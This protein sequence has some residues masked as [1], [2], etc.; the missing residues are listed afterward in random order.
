M[1]PQVQLTADRGLCLQQ[2]AEMH[3]KT[4]K[5]RIIHFSRWL[6]AILIVA[7]ATVLF[8]PSIINWQI[9]RILK[10]LMPEGD[11]AELRLSHVGIYRSEF[12]LIVHDDK[13]P[14]NFSVRLDSGLLEYHPLRLL[15]RQIDSI[16]ISG[17]TV[18]L[19]ATNGVLNV[20]AADLFAKEGESEPFT[21]ES[22][23]SLPVKVSRVQIDG[24]IVAKTA[25]ELIVV[26]L[27]VTAK[28]NEGR[29][30]D[31]ISG[32]A[33][34]MLASNRLSLDMEC[35]IQKQTASATVDGVFSSFSLPYSLRRLIPDFLYGINANTEAAANVRFNGAKLAEFEVHTQLDA[36]AYTASGPI[37]LRPEIKASGDA[38]RFSVSVTGIRSDAS[39]FPV[40]FNATNILCDVSAGTVDGTAYIGISSNT[41]LAIAFGYAT[42]SFHAATKPGDTANSGSLRVGDVAFDY[43]APSTALKATFE[44]GA[45]RADLSVGIPYVSYTAADTAAT[46]FI[47]KADAAGGLGTITASAEASADLVFRDMEVA[48]ISA[49]GRLPKAGPFV[50]EGNIAAIGATLKF[51]GDI[52]PSDRGGIRATNYIAMAE[53]PL[54]LTTIQKLIP[55]LDGVEIKTKAKVSGGYF[56]EGGK[57]GGAV[58]LV[59]SEGAVDWPE[60]RFSAS[61]IRLSFSL[62][63]LPELTSDSQ[64]LRFKNLKYRRAEVESG[65]LVF[66]MHSP[67]VWF[68]DNL[69]LD[70]C[71]GKVRGESTRLSPEN[72]RTRITLH[73]DRINVSKLLHQIGIGMDSGG[74]GEISGTIPV[75]ISREDGVVFRDAFLYSTPGEK[76]HIELAPSK[77]VLDAAEESVST[78]LAVDAL[79]SFDYSW[80]RIGLNT[81]GEVL[82]AKLQMDGKPANKLYYSVGRDGI[83]KSSQPVRF[84]G[85]V[86]DAS[87]NIPLA[88]TLSLITNE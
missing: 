70:W 18:R 33:T 21:L 39:G 73:A 40:T 5:K 74:A 71:G 14:E 24:G 13:L 56:F 46:N 16:R 37:A 58:H 67:T 36:S 68:L 55:E 28:A 79:R 63:K 44:E 48:N 9:N 87:F 51:G 72:R 30:W 35:D 80:M 41:P 61:D 52:A 65:R 57:S 43:T 86:L 11:V 7:L 20:P 22:I 83:V 75:V 66:R 29:Q 3:N 77:A 12:S 47:L 4:E 17:L 76:G 31:S 15:S 38:S 82:T 78:S 8:A 88:E 1:P 64:M 45:L 10:D 59:L 53:Q 19:I 84:Q 85:I 6:S 32:H 34:L 50:Y 42:N 49:I 23:R 2:S 81:E 62:P 69:N 27:Y 25:D 54:D 26:P 60:K